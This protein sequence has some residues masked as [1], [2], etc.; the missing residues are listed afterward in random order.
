MS[1]GRAK[2]PWRPKCVG[3][4]AMEQLPTF[5]SAR[6]T[7]ETVPNVAV[8]PCRGRGRGQ[9][10]RARLEGPVPTSLSHRWPWSPRT[11]RLSRGSRSRSCGRSSTRTR[12]RGVRGGLP[13]PGGD[14]RGFGEGAREVLPFPGSSSAFP[15]G[16]GV[17]EHLQ[18]GAADPTGTP[19]LDW[20]F[21]P[22]GWVCSP[23]PP[24]R[25]LWDPRVGVRP[26]PSR[27]LSAPSGA[28]SGGA[29][30]ASLPT[31]GCAGLR[32]AANY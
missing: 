12:A 7:P 17:G 9:G 8:S 11:A 20:I 25:P 32:V 27:D 30:G 23:H 14:L 10:A 19:G 4:V 1:P 22:P 15:W 3:F 21:R 18:S 28:G 6:V 13:V 24:A 16:K 26:P 31:L 29:A 2:R 5:P